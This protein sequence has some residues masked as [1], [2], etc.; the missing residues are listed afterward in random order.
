MGF[1]GYTSD[2]LALLDEMGRATKAGAAALKPRIDAE[3]TEP[4]RDLV[5][6]LGA[7]LQDRVSP[8]LQAVPKINGSISP[9]HRDLRFSADKDHPLKDHVHLVFWEGE[10]KGRAATLRLRI[11]AS[12]VG[13]AATTDLRDRIPRWRDLV[14]SDAGAELADA[15][16]A[17]R[18]TQR[19]LAVGDPDLK[20][21]P[22]GYGDEH[23]R[24]DL[25]R[26]RSLFLAGAT[27]HP[28]AIHG[29]RFVDWCAR[30]LEAMAEVHRWSVTHL[31]G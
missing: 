18:R 21:V 25:L 22:K 12:D 10:P 8:G 13:F 15:I 4:T 11:T 5:E 27:A 2:A 14:A 20:T 1:S 9:F 24:A 28:K 17:A 16:A 30:R 3:L 23:P 31:V 7:E 26:R 29:P 19:F 6:A